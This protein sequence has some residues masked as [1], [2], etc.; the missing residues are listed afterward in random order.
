MNSRGLDGVVAAE[1]KLSHVDGERG[2]L[3]IAGYRIDDLAPNATFEET[4]WLLWNGDLPDERELANFRRELAERRSCEVHRI[5]G[6]EPL[7][8]IRMLLPPG[9]DPL[10][11]VAKFPTI[12]AAVWRLSRNE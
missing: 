11:I 9:D 12:V 1:T 2:E 5:L 8:T 6:V 7:D 10:D 4:V 3:I